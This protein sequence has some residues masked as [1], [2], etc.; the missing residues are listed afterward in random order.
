MVKI[1]LKEEHITL[2][3][4]A[5]A[6]KAE[7]KDMENRKILLYVLHGTWNTPYTDG[8][9]VV[10]ISEDIEP[11]QKKLC[12]IIDNK[13]G[14][15]LEHP[16]EYIKQEIGERH[17][18]IIDS[19]GRYAKFYIT[20]HFVEISYSL[21]GAISR[22]MDKIYRERDIESYLT[23]M[24]ECE[25]IE[26]WKYEYMANSR[27]VIQKIVVQFEKYEDCNLSFNSTMDM[28]VEEAKKSI[29]LDDKVLEFL[30]ERLSD[31]PVDE[32]GCIEE[33]FMGYI[34]GTNREEIWHWFAENNFDIQSKL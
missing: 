2:M 18:E 14:D 19:D 1:E 29:Q 5:N 8:S 28:V 33:D 3:S 23:E 21:M 22:E 34:S 7:V 27:E 30:W 20:E 25:K 6:V 13:A 15:Y 4:K 26:N 17:Y 24:W 32:D 12:E 11:L 16:T 10:G 9:T 31:I